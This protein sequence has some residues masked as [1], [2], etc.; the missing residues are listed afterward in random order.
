MDNRFHATCKTTRSVCSWYCAWYLSCRAL[1][2]TALSSCQDSREYSFAT[3]GTKIKR[4]KRPSMA[5]VANHRMH[6]LWYT[7]FVLLNI[8]VEH[9]RLRQVIYILDRT[10][11]YCFR[12]YVFARGTMTSL[13][14]YADAYNETPACISGMFSLAA[15]LALLLRSFKILNTRDKRRKSIAIVGFIILSISIVLVLTA[16]FSACIAFSL[17][18]EELPVSDT[19][20]GK[21]ACFIDQSGSCSGCDSSGPRCPE[22]SN[23]NVTRIIQSQAKAGASLAGIFLI[24]AFG[25]LRYGLALRAHMSNYMID[26]V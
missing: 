26:Y 22:W 16:V 21:I 24:Y 13:R 10:S 8:C 6:R 23:D 7:L 2:Q 19:I 5:S 18:F 15:V 17:S 3:T 9:S 11:L 1:F 12:R 20:R 25:T 4:I 14:I